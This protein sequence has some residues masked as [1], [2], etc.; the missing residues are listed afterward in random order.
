MRILSRSP[1]KKRHLIMGRGV[2]GAPRRGPLLPR[3]SRPQVAGFQEVLGLRA[4]LPES[5]GGG[6]VSLFDRHCRCAVRKE[7]SWL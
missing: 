3:G 7:F 2:A 4:Q 1:E 6:W 5:E